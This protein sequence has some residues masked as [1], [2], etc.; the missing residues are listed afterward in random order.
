MFPLLSARPWP[1]HPQPG[2]V[3]TLA[4]SRSVSARDHRPGPRTTSR[5][6]THP[7]RCPTPQHPRRLIIEPDEPRRGHPYATPHDS[8]P[9]LTGRFFPEPRTIPRTVRGGRE[10]LPDR[11]GCLPGG[12]PLD[13]RN[14]MHRHTTRTTPSCP[15]PVCHPHRARHHGAPR[16]I[17]WHPSRIMRPF[18]HAATARPGR[19]E[20]PS[21]AR[22]G[23]CS[24]RPG[25]TWRPS[26]VR[27]TVGFKHLRGYRVVLGLDGAMRVGV[28]VRS[29]ESCAGWAIAGLGGP[30]LLR[31][32]TVVFL[33]VQ[34]LLF[35]PHRAQV[36]LA[37]G[38][39]GRLRLVNDRFCRVPS[40]PQ[41]CA[42][43]SCPVAAPARVAVVEWTSSSGTSDCPLP[44]AQMSQETVRP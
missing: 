41:R 42:R 29:T 16:S 30:L 6:S 27:F 40:R 34:L 24:P 4:Y 39:A 44:S 15:V 28:A 37:Y 11:N 7:P 12:G 10:D 21:G 35:R 17:R 26:R 9:Q 23:P 36:V 1:H 14:I 33:S 43:R 13:T 31:C 32:A 38:G 2:L 22:T 19:P 3:E 18:G 8:H 5:A 20:V 25:P